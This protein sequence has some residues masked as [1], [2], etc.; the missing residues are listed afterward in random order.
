M[1][2]VMGIV[3]GHH[4]A[5]IVESDVGKGTSVRVL[6]PV[7]K[8]VQPLAVTDVEI[9]ETKSSVPDSATK[10]KTVLVVDG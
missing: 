10:R 5:I 1:A 6:F 7:S 8:E 9:A 2:E 4:G 3:K